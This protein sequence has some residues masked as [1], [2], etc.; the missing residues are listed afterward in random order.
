MSGCFACLST[1]HVWLSLKSS[2]S[3]SRPKS[4]ESSDCDMAQCSAVHQIT[5][6]RQSTAELAF[7]Q[8]DK[9]G[10]GFIEPL[11][12]LPHEQSSSTARSNPTFQCLDEDGDGRISEAEW[13]EGTASVVR[14]I[15]AVRQNTA[16]LAFDQLDKDG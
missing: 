8:L 14:Q 1:A 2:S 6:V 3:L 16:E 7:E 15:T 13:L 10:D 12:L 9:D 11:E 5:A 4:V